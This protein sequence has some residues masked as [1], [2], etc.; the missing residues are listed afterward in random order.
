[1]RATAIELSLAP[2]RPADCC[3]ESEPELLHRQVRA[4]AARRGRDTALSMLLLILTLPLL[5]IVACMIKLE[6]PGPV[7]Y[8]QNR[9]GLG[10]RCFSLWKFRSM[11]TDA[12]AAGASWAAAR[13]PR[14]TRVGGFIRA[15]RIDELPQLVNV[16]RGE[17]SLIGPRPERPI[18]VE[19][20]IQVIPGFAAR[21]RVLPGLTG[22]AQVNYPYGASVEDAR[23]KLEYDLYYIRER[24][25][26]LD[27]RILLRTVGVVLCRT[28]AR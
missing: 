11:R 3:F 26:L 21:T 20:L 27:L 14:I 25:A 23:I 28:G 13:D 18:F 5:L 24:S 12:E 2:F 4:N 8:R 6:S 19:Q 17:M 9:V 16:L 7:L 22:W 10:G 15:H 1:M